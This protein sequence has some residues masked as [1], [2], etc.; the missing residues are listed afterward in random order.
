MRLSLTLPISIL[1][2]SALSPALPGETALFLADGQTFAL[3][4]YEV[5]DAPVRPTDTTALKL[6]VTLHET[7]RSVTTLTAERIVEQ[8]F[9]R[10]ED[11]FRYIPGVFTRSQDGDSYHF[12][13]RGFDMG[14]DETKIDGF[15][16]LLAGGTFSPTLFGVEQ[17]VYLRGPA[18]LQY[19]AAATPGGVINLI[20]K[21]PLFTSDFTRLEARF[22]TY[23]GNGLALGDHGSALVSVDTNHLLRN[24][25]SLAYRV[26][27]QAQ[28][29]ASYKNGILDRQR[30]FLASL[31]WKFGSDQRFSLTPLLEYQKQPFGAG[32][33]VSISPSTSRSTSD[34]AVGPIRTDDL[35]P[36]EL[37]YAAGT[38]ILTHQLAGLDFSAGLTERWKAQAAYRYIRADSDA[39][40]FTPQTA[41]LRQLDPANP[42]SW[43]IDRRQSVS[44]T[45][46]RNHAFDVQT[47]YEFEPVDGVKNLT[48]LGWNGRFYRTTASRSAATQRNQS[49]INI[50]T[51]EALSPLVDDHPALVDSYLTDDFYWNV[52]AQNQTSLHERWVATLGVGYGQQH[53]DR[54][55]PATLPPP[56]NLEE[57]LATRRGDVTPNAALVFNATR[58]LALYASYS[59]SYSPPPG[60][61]EDAQGDTGGFQPTTGT[62]HEIGAKL[63]WP[64]HHAAATVSVFQ[65]ELDNVL[66]Q[67]DVADLNPRGN[68][69]YVQTGGGRRTRG[70]EFSAEIRPL[71][72][73]HVQATASYLDS[74]YRGEGRLPNTR[75]ERTPPWAFSLYQRYDFT[76]GALKGFG[77]SA[78]LIWQDQRWSAARTAEA[79]DPLLLPAYT[80]VDLGLFYRLGAHWDFSLHAENALDERYFV[81]GTTGAALELG[82]PCSLSLRVGYRF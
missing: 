32:R 29:Q 66:V 12:L 6:P 26:T 42:A 39:N 74:R 80:R 78:G 82:A 50:T 19:G 4:R 7:P 73:W 45:D 71:A 69:Y 33:A 67:S 9:Q 11:T 16:G 68:R 25:G 5:S 75:T 77:F 53:Y 18:G 60:E 58:Q 34:G 24:D 44:Q 62:N 65:T 13:A 57:I 72:G 2:F 76:R 8:D 31:T 64:E 48:Q 3:S 41:T 49:P 28:N 27:A 81:N 63:D 61:Y 70:V 37:N 17:V 15:S 35:T 55:Y 40:Q 47:T 30:A 10:L 22:G 52:Y 14:P 79:P 38:R 21:K 46:R 20:T 59:T 54:S 56:A 23:A 36:L 51:G 1:S 43:V